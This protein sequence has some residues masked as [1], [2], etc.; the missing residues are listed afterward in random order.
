M[1]QKFIGAQVRH[2]APD[3]IPLEAEKA[4]C[5]MAKTQLTK[6]FARSAYGT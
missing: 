3:Q 6:K 2:F 5:E 4:R 1:M